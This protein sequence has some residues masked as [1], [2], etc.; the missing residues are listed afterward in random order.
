MLSGGRWAIRYASLIDHFNS[1]ERKTLKD[2]MIYVEIKEETE[3]QGE[4]I[5]LNK[6]NRNPGKVCSRSKIY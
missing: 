6:S 2:M 1:H 3:Q 5:S 4:G